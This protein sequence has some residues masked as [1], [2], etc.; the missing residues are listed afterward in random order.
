M[1]AGRPYLSKTRAVLYHTDLRQKITRSSRL[2]NS[3][4]KTTFHGRLVLLDPANPS[5]GGEKLSEETATAQQEE[6]AAKAH[7]WQRIVMI[8]TPLGAVLAAVINIGTIVS[9]FTGP[10]LP[11]APNVNILSADPR[12]SRL[13]E[14]FTNVRTYA[15]IGDTQNLEIDFKRLKQ[16]TYPRDS[17]RSQLA[18][19]ENRQVLSQLRASKDREVKEYLDEVGV[20]Q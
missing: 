11:K 3:P 6:Q 18:S 19:Q 10:V 2:K 20:Q 7:K 17:V 8:A 13:K 14:E 12:E 15:K 5:A 16:K 9:W 4:S 1:R